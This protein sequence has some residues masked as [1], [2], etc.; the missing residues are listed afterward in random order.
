[1][2]LEYEQAFNKTSYTILA[3]QNNLNQEII[4]EKEVFHL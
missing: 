2:F 4:E 3:Y 1:M